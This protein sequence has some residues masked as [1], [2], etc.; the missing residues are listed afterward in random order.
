MR[1]QFLP[2]GVAGFA[3]DRTLR[4]ANPRFFELLAVPPDSLAPGAP[5]EAL[6]PRLPPQA[7]GRLTGRLDPAAGGS[8]QWRRPDD[9][10][11]DMAGAPLPDGGRAVTLV[12]VSALAAAARRA[13][14]RV[15]T[16]QAILEALPHGVCV[17]GPD[18]RVSLFNQ[19]Y[20]QVMAGAP[21]AVGDAIEDVIRRRAEAGEYGP[22]RPEEVI[23]QQMAFDIA[24]PQSR[25]RRRPNGTMLD[26]R[27]APMP[28]GGH[29][30]VVTDITALTEAEAEV[31]RHAAEMAAMLGAIRHGI[32][33]WG[34]DHRLIASNAI[35]AELLHHPPGALTPGRHEETLLSDMLQRG[36]LGTGEGAQTAVQ[37]LRGRD[38]SVPYERETVTSTGRVLAI[39][40][41][42]TPGGGWV[43][44][45]SDATEARRAEE[46]LRR[47]K[48]AAE[49]ASQAKSRFLATMSHELRTP[50]NAVIGFSDAMLREADNP[51]PARVAEFARQIN[52]SGRSLLSLI[53]LILDVARIESGRFE[54]ALDRVDIGRLI[55]NAVRQ[56]EAAAQAAGLTLAANLP[57]SL[58]AIRGDERRLA[59]V[60]GHLVSNAIKFTAAGTIA[61]SARKQPDGGLLVA[62]KDTGIGIPT[63]D[64]E[65]VFQPFTQLEET[66]SRRFD[67]VG[68]GL[69]LSRALVAAHGGTLTLDSKLGEGT[70]VELRFPASQVLRSGTR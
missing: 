69:Y 49:A 44:T 17:Y 13:E 40:S 14:D 70:V 56:S 65:R 53:N 4:F 8:V 25:R 38:R 23:A 15:G 61:V 10:V 7:A 62:V 29:I 66:L 54:L 63:E 43:T 59:E 41:D 6:L 31:T 55:R 35:A 60:L 46:E 2:V 67:G 32:L 11:I 45:F 48:E 36:E 26:V 3:A 51:S 37:N 21:V 5:V 18:R 33:L 20:A 57:P 22:G 28:D 64:L 39:R 24:R 1:L 68:L 16:L 9:T 50:L 34:A 19:A 30:S 52:E 27:T 47:A 42:P 58:P 12:D